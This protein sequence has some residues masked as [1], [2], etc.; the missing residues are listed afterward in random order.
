MRLQARMGIISPE[1]PPP[2]AP[3]S[4]IFAPISLIP[5]PIPRH[6]FA[7]AL[8]LQRAYNTL[9]ARVALDISFLDQIMGPGGVSDVDEFIFSLWS[10]WKKLRD[11]GS[12]PCALRV[13]RS[14]VPLHLGLFRS[15][16]LLHQPTI[17]DP[18]SLKQVEFNTIASSF[19]P[20]SQRVAGMHRYLIESTGYFGISPL[21]SSSN[22]P[23]NDT[24]KEAHRA[25]G[26]P[27]CCPHLFVV[28]P[29]DRNVF[30]Q[31]MLEYQLFESHEISVVYYR[32]GYGPADYASATESSR[33]VQCP[34]IALQLAG[35]KKVQEVLM[36]P[37]VLE[38]FL[39]PSEGAE[40][41]RNSWVSMW[42]LDTGADEALP[43]HERVAWVAMEL[44]RPPRGVGAFLVRQGAGGCARAREVRE[45]QVGWLVRTKA[46]DVDEGG[47][48]AGFSVLD[49][50][51]LVD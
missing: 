51:L 9:Y 50:V 44:I 25:Y 39:A 12:S 6:L 17:D 31:R 20:L 8:T 19:G 33:A 28:Q 46:D 1:K 45:E 42:S 7:N 14:V 21:L 48:A 36:R 32:A 40:A 35:A 43:L 3:E 26:V 23:T 29:N 15:D 5:T 11:E 4:A 30:D 24:I 2:S 38:R 16:Y 10:V 41:V 47:V 18:I 13:S 22:L 49:S 27:E 34:S 37:G